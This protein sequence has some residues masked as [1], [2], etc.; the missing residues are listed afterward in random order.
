MA[1][2]WMAGEASKGIRTDGS[3]TGTHHLVES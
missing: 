3:N 1:L 2:A